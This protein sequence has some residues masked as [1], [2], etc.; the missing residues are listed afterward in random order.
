MWISGDVTVSLATDLIIGAARRAQIPV[1]TSLPSNA[2]RGT[3]FDLGADFLDVGR[4]AGQLA[5]DVLDG[6]NPASIPVENFAPEVFVFNETVLG[7][8]REQWTIPESVRKRASGW[9]TATTTNLPKPKIIATAKSLKPQP[10]RTYKIGLAYFAPEAGADSCMK[11]IWDGLKELGFVEGRNLVV[12]RSHAQGEIVNI[13][14]ILQNFDSSDNDLVLC[15][16][17]P[18]IGGACGLV[19]H[20]PVVFTY[21]RHRFLPAR[22]GHG[23]FHQGDPAFGEICGNNL[24]CLGGKFGKSYPGR[25]RGLR[26]R[27][28]EA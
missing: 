14:G 9:I 15:M 18:V 21:Y 23:E 5:A 3:L 16:S 2:G 17:T 25:S 22:P 4:A 6:K 19:K 13:P 27:W 12:R 26:H 7:S 28:V 1:F 24:Q 11:G 10:G 20:K 8:L